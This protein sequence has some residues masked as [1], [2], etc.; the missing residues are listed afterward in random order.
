[1][2]AIKIRDIDSNDIPF[3]F[4]T[5]LKSYKH[6]SAFAKRITNDVFFDFHHRLV[7]AIIRRPQTL[8]KVACLAEDPFVIIGY[9]VSEDTRPAVIHYLFVKKAFRQMRV[10]QILLNTLE[11]DPGECVFTHWSYDAD[12]LLRKYPNATYNPYLI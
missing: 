6:S 8:I 4:S 1:M 7:D 12:H 3:I 5:W 10:A 11:Q 9:L 2:E